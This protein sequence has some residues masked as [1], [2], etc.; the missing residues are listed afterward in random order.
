MLRTGLT[1]R[2]DVLSADPSASP[3]IPPCRLIG[4]A[5]LG[6]RTRWHEHRDAKGEPGRRGGSEAAEEAEM[7]DPVPPQRLGRPAAPGRAEEAR[8]VQ[9]GG[10]PLLAEFMMTTASFLMYHN[11]TSY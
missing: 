9:T 11:F 1:L 5:R 2:D 10:S 7:G 4:S 3:G 6:S 8:D